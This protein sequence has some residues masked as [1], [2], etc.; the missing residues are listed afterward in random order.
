M[1]LPVYQVFVDWNTDGDFSDTGEDISAYVKRITIDRGRANV[2]R[3]VVAGTVEIK[4]VN[5]DGRFSPS[6]G[7]SPLTGLL[8]NRRV[9]V[10]ATFGGSTYPL[11]AGY[12]TDIIPHPALGEQFCYIYA[13]D[14]LKRLSETEITLAMQTAQTADSII[15]AILTAAGWDPGS[16]WGSAIDSQPDEKIPYAHWGKVSAM[17][18]IGELEDSTLGMAYIGTDGKFVWEGR[19]HRLL[20][21][22]L[23][24]VAII[25]DTTAA[26]DGATNIS[27]RLGDRGI[28]NV[29]SAEYVERKAGLTKQVLW[30]MDIGS[31][32]TKDKP[33]FIPLENTKLGPNGEYAAA[34]LEARFSS[35]ALSVNTPVAQVDYNAHLGPRVDWAINKSSSVP[36]TLAE[37]GA[38]HALVKIVNNVGVPVWITKL[39][40]TGQ[41]LDTEE[42][43]SVRAMDAGSITAY[44]RVETKLEGKF[45]P[46]LMVAQDFV[47]YVKDEFHEPV[48]EVTVSLI[49]GTDALTTQILAREI[50]DRVKLVSTLLGLNEDYFV[51]KINH[52]IEPPAIHRCTWVVTK[53][54][55]RT[56][57]TLGISAL[58]GTHVLAY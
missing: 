4:L 23:V 49:N 58:G 30:K 57:F 32:G 16:V 53:C 9:K 10:Q 2:L 38:E 35:P 41:V 39:Q 33:L 3:K 40:I 12:L 13:S 44:G 1:A 50:S 45:Y 43:A 52:E 17:S 7:A 28:V 34:W 54:T 55:A 24:A 48:A 42:P 20:A 51:E 6:N 37:V 11:F 5:N 46:S 56:F 14:A 25:Y 27:Y 26:G 29:A 21:P 8:P 22:H 31:D 19:H 47:D 15:G 18:A 36:V